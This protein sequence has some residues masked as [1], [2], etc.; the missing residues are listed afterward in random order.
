[1]LARLILLLGVLLAASPALAE[2]D[3]LAPETLSGM[4]DLRLA[5]SQGEKS[6]LN[7]DLGKTRVGGDGFQASVGE[8]D[9]AWRPQFDWEWSGL[10]EAEDQPD[11]DG[12]PRI[13]QAYLTYKPVPTGETRYSVRAGL[14]YPPISEEHSGP[15]WT[16]TETITPSAINSWVGEEV[17]VAALEATVQRAVGGQ[18][19]S[20]TGAVFGYNDTAGTLLVAR[21][22]S[23]DDVRTGTP[24]Q[25]QLPP[26]GGILTHVQATITTP[27]LNLDSRPGGYGRVDWRPRGD[28]DLNL[29]YYDNAGDR[30]SRQAHQWAWRTRFWNLG[31]RYDLDASTTLLGQ[32]MTGSTQM[33]YGDPDLWV[34]TEFSAGYLMA[35]RRLGD[36]S[37]SARADLFQTVNRADPDYGLTQERGWA[38]GF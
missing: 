14:F 26:L 9:I 8:A 18:T 4:L 29:F 7:H 35:V 36:D 28:L 5:D 24:S 32:A 33:G 11:H 31:L 6:W 15:F 19:V 22:W 2:P 30:I 1:M 3:F 38:L 27:V 37:V 13:G 17:K 34:K 16:P 10:V 12:G 23:L 20:L 21:G 25:Y